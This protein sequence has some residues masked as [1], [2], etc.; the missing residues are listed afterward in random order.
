VLESALILPGPRAWVT[1]PAGREAPRFPG[2]DSAPSIPAPST[3]TGE[4]GVYA[5]LR[6]LDAIREAGMGKGPPGRP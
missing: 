3:L 1:G 2:P 5:A 4:C 6:L